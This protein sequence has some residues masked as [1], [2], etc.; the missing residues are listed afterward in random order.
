MDCQDF[1]VVTDPK[2]IQCV[3]CK[4]LSGNILGDLF[5]HSWILL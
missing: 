1:P 5:H 2:E 3:V 4:A